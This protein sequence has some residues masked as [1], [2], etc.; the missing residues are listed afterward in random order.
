[1]ESYY[2]AAKL[3]VATGLALQCSL[4]AVQVWALSRHRQL[5][6]ALLVAG[7][8]VGLMYAA[9]AASPLIFTMG[10]QGRTLLAQASVA[11]LALGGT[12]GVWGMVLFIRSYGRLIRPSAQ[13]ET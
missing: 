11:L 10:L 12:L 1:M 5:H 7:A 4:L 3:L 9:V 13:A 6:F 2:F 8:F